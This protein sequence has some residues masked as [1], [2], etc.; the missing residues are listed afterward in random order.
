MTP[1]ERAAYEGRVDR[2]HKLA[3]RDRKLM[4]AGQAALDW[5]HDTGS[6]HFCSYHNISSANTRV[7]EAEDASDT[8]KLVERGRR[9]E[10][11]CPLLGIEDL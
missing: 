4:A 6:C 2:L 9:H 10:D 11:F 3:A 8:A 1:E 7:L 5:A